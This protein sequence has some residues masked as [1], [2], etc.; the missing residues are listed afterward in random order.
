MKTLVLPLLILLNLWS[1]PLFSQCNVTGSLIDRYG[2]N[3][4]A[5][6]RLNGKKGPWVGQDGNFEI[7]DVPNGEFEIRLKYFGY[8]DIILKCHCDTQ[9]IELGRIYM[10]S[11]RFWLDGPKKGY[12]VN[13]YSNGSLKDSVSIKKYQLHNS[14]F[15]NQ[16][17][18]MSQQLV[19]D[20]NRL[21]K[22]F[23]NQFGQINELE[24]EID[25][26]G[27]INYAQQRL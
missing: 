23:I 22:I 25:E 1:V 21:Q 20:K 26:Y 5:E 11:D 15:Y 2:N 12:I 16:T 13:H 7:T 27:S 14:K 9:N 3:G 19:F 8:R 10:I 6:I 4:W 24:F 18:V 17:G